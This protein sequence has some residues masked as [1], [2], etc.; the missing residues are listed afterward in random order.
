MRT[1]Q[2]GSFLQLER[3]GYFFV[4]SVAFGDKKMVLNFVPDGKTKS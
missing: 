2:K 4:D 1:L 3:R